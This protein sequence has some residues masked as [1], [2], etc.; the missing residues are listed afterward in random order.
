MVH[1]C[2]V[3]TERADTAAVS[4][5][6]SHIA[7]KERCKHAI[8]VEIQKC[9]IKSQLVMTCRITR[10]R[11]ES[12]RDRRIALYKSDQQLSSSS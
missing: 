4:R 11:I 1:G 8:S 2:K 10:E 7:I 12:V 5:G 9:T 6:S 3:H